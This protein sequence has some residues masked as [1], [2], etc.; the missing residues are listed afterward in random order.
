MKFKNVKKKIYKKEKSPS[1]SRNITEQSKFSFLKINSADLLRF[2]GWTLKLFVFLVFIVAVIIVGY[3]LQRNIQMKE[4]VDS[5]REVLTKNLIFWE[6][7]IATHSD[8][9]DAYFQASVLEYKLGNVAKAKEY[10]EKGLGINPFSSD[11]RKLEQ[12][13]KSR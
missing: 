11:G 1:N 12:F 8:Y 7:F 13:L 4:V 2:G 3:D 9:G 6:D 10:T 5:E